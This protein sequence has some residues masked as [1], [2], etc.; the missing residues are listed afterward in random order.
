MLLISRG[1]PN[2]TRNITVSM[3]CLAPWIACT[4]LGKIVQRDGRCHLKAGKKL[5]VQPRCLKHCQ[6]IIYGSGVYHWTM[7]GCWMIWTFWICHFC[8]SCW[9]TEHSQS[10]CRAACLSHLKLLKTC[11]IVYLYLLTGSTPHTHDLSKASNHHWSMPNSA[12]LL[13]RMHQGKTWNAPL[14]S[15]KVAFRWWQGLFLEFH[16]RN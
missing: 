9:L 4:P 3:G 2:Y 7:L 15:F 16:W 14:G 1:F 13:G 5:A 8:W 12:T 10:R 11:F 6:I